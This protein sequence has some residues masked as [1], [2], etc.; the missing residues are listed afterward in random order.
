MTKKPLTSEQYAK[1]KAPAFIK[2]RLG[3]H[4][5]TVETYLR[6][7]AD[8]GFCCASCGS[9]NPASTGKKSPLIDGWHFAWA[10]DHDHKTGKVRGLLC[11]PCNLALGLVNDDPAILEE[12]IKYLKV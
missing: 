3:K 1:I 12:M 5:L 4:G 7:L 9:D 11:R 2:F 10:I 8:Q 6:T